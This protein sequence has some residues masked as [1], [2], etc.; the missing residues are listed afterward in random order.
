MQICLLDHREPD[1]TKAFLTSPNVILWIAKQIGD[2][3]SPEKWVLDLFCKKIASKNQFRLFFCW[4]FH[5][6][7]PP[8]GKIVLLQNSSI[9]I[10]TLQEK[11]SPSYHFAVSNDFLKFFL[12]RGILRL[13]MSWILTLAP[14]RY[15]PKIIFFEKKVAFF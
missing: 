13:K 2:P 8:A 3:N 11:L 4:K 1:K 15:P 6:R 12:F 9:I 10:V 5:A 7:V 14:P